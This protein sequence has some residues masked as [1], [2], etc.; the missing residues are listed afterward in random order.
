MELESG[1]AEQASKRPRGKD[2]SSFKLTSVQVFD[3]LQAYVIP[4]VDKKNE[5]EE[6]NN[7]VDS[8]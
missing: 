7:K 3:L 5:F 1:F 6:Q 4:R 2:Q 8:N